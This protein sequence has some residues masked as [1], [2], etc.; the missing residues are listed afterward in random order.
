LI[1]VN[2]SYLLDTN[3][4][5]APIEKEPAVQA[6]FAAA[7]AIFVPATVLGELYFGAR[8]SGTVD[9][10]LARIDDFMKKNSV[11][12]CDA[13]TAAHYGMIREVLR[14]TGRPIPDNDIWIAATARQHDLILVT[15]DAHFSAVPDLT[16][17]AW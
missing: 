4:V 13:G 8:K 7:P 16:V 5:I 14:A 9:A 10:N 12:P 15:R 3:I 6:R 11:L 2:G 17:E 1:S